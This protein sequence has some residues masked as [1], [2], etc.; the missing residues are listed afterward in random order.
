MH[1]DASI[2]RTR[3]VLSLLSST[4]DISLD[5]GLV[6]LGAVAVLVGPERLASLDCAPIIPGD[7]AVY[8]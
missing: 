4:E 2:N 3:G 7:I 8:P 1:P 5:G 6:F